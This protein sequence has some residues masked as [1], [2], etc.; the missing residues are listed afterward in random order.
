LE[1]LADRYKTFYMKH[2]SKRK[3]FTHRYKRD[4][5][6]SCE[7]FFLF[8]GLTNREDVLRSRE[9]RTRKQDKEQQVAR[10][11]CEICDKHFGTEWGLKVHK[12]RKHPDMEK[13]QSR[14][15]RKMK[16]LPILDSD[17]KNGFSGLGQNE[18]RDRLARAKRLNEMLRANLQRMLM[19][20]DV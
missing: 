11:T 7:P 12:A 5:R 14:K 8:W 16:G 17:D 1:D 20:M 4:R 13:Q 19:E 3:V 10:L 9:I 18:L 15:P 2:L 6:A